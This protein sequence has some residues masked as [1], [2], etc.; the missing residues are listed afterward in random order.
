MS[1]STKDQMV[2]LLAAFHREALRVCGEI[3]R[4]MIQKWINSP[5]VFGEMLPF[6]P[7]YLREMIERERAK[8]ATRSA[9]P[10]WRVLPLNPTLRTADDFR[11]ALTAG[12][13]RI[14][15]WADDILSRAN[16]SIPKGVTKLELC[17]AS[18]ADLGFPN[19]AKYADTCR[20]ILDLGDDLCPARTGPELR[21]QYYSDQPM[22]E[23][24][25][26]ATEP[27][28]DSDGYFDAWSVGHGSISRWLNGVNGN[29]SCFWG[30]A[31][32]FV[33]VRRKPARNA[34]A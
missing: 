27:I 34:T 17:V 33:F 16:L 30:G 32:R 9:F 18:N 13:F 8:F 3:S 22:S 7:D 24:L 15:S 11:R 29:P 12:G 14:G 4:E 19:G 1:Q 21:I 23:W 31:R 2:P 5:Q 10:I 25:T 26:I 28:A 20:R 6:G